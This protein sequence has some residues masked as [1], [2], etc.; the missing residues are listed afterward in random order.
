MN[1]ICFLL[2]KRYQMG[3][4][5]HKLVQCS[6]CKEFKSKNSFYKSNHSWDKLNLYCNNCVHNKYLERK[7]RK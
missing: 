3:N 2:Q 6:L 4:K 1:V 7:N 5:K